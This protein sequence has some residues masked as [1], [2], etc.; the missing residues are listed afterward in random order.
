MFG[1]PVSVGVSPPSLF[2]CFCVCVVQA[3]LELGVRGGAAGRD[4]LE[5]CVRLVYSVQE[6]LALLANPAVP[7]LVAGAGNQEQWTGQPSEDQEEGQFEYLTVEVVQLLQRDQLSVEGFCLA[8]LSHGAR[9]VKDVVTEG[10]DRGAGALLGTVSR[11]VCAG[12]ELLKVCGAGEGGLDA[13]HGTVRALACSSSGWVLCCGWLLLEASV[14]H[15]RQ[16]PALV[17]CSWQPT[18]HRRGL[19][20]R[21]CLTSWPSAS[22]NGVAG[23]RQPGCLVWRSPTNSFTVSCLVDAS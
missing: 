14:T 15:S 3:L 1:D 17:Q 12:V 5:C 18:P 9:A 16:L 2:R 21:V 22:A 7:P 20:S 8:L 23:W 6:R 13:T 19:L 4:A 10:L 11:L